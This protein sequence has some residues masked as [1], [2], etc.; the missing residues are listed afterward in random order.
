[1]YHFLIIG[2][3]L[4]GTH[5][6]NQLLQAGKRVLVVDNGLPNASSRVAAG[7]INPVTGKR[8]VKSW[9]ID[10]LLPPALAIYKEL[11]VLLEVKVLH[12]RTI[13]SVFSDAES[14]NTWLARTAQ[15]GYDQYI[16]E[17]NHAA[18]YAP[19]LKN[20]IGVGAI[21]GGWQV[22]LPLLLTKFRNFLQEN[23]ALSEDFFQYKDLILSENSVIWKDNTF[24]KVIFCEGIVAK[25]NPFFSYLPFQGDKGELLLVKIPDFK[26]ESVLK[27]HQLTIVPME[28]DLFWV[29]ATFG[30]NADNDLPSANGEISL[31][32]DLNAAISLPFEVVAHRAA[33]RPTM[34]GDRRPFVGLHPRHNQLGILNGLGSK[35]TSLVP[36]LAQHFAEHLVNDEVLLKDMDVKRFEKWLNIA[37]STT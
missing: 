1:M 24:E 30:K 13:F 36:F 5:L 11:E 26:S 18:E 16:A 7:L 22:N 33:I 15:E 20:A 35:G 29:G 8:I 9:M 4:A 28:D 12:Q 25:N 32:K 2:Q 34:I 10:Q 3:G 31:L 19:Y 37:K 21:V 6:A 23:N 14:Q 17:A 27:H